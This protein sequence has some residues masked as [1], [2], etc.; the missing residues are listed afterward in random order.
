MISARL[1]QILPHLGSAA[2]A[3]RKKGSGQVWILLLLSSL[4][5][6]RVCAQQAPAFAH[7][8]DMPA[9]HNPGAVGKSPNLNIIAA[10]QTHALGYE[11]AGGT[12]YAG[13]DMA[14]QLGRSRH[15]AGVLF[16]KDQ[17]GL[18]AHQRFAVQY[19]YQQKLW[20]GYLGIGVQADLLN[21]KIDGTNVDLVDGNDPAFPATELS[22]SKVGVSAGLFYKHK[23][24]STGL[25]VMHITAPTVLMGETNE[26]KV[27]RLYNFTAEYNI[28][29][30]NPLFYIVPSTMLR[31]DGTAFRADVTARL[32][33]MKG[34]QRIYG[35]LGYS[36]L[37]SVTLFVGGRL[38]G[39]DISYSYEA[40]TEGI[41]LES[42]FHEV[43]LGYTLDLD[44]AK[45]GKNLHR[46]VRF[47]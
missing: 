2:F 14:F 24:W 8:W 9:Q 47:L 4:M 36:P 15:G 40:N 12:M 22:G 32:L 23:S 3:Q 41:G 19:A 31:Y 30:K 5:A 17:I 16:E 10:Y 21:E 6:G 7:Y 27:K 44:F 37:R 45:K 26:I 33:Y 35:G 28:R 25:S 29:T 13:A 38:K 43:T 42:G 20:G 11:D 46:S 39:V 34:Q 18:F 1:S